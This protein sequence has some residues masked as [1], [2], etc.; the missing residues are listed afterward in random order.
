MVN[1]PIIPE[2][3]IENLSYEFA[4]GSDIT[5]INPLCPRSVTKSNSSL[6]TWAHAFSGN[7][8]LYSASEKPKSQ[9][10]LVIVAQLIRY[11]S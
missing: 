10:N 6:F 11:H 1:T 8:S 9:N 4:P 5:S 2:K 3:K 7:S